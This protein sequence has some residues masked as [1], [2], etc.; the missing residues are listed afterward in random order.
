MLSMKY[1][2]SFLLG[3]RKRRSMHSIG[4]NSGYGAWTAFTTPRNVESHGLGALISILLQASGCHFTAYPGF[5]VSV[6][7]TCQRKYFSSLINFIRFS[8][9]FNAT[10]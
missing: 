7:T 4:F 1:D 8:R 2:N 10:A 3:S 9:N 5:N 6:S